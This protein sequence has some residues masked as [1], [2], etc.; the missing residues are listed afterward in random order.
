MSMCKYF[1]Y[2][3]ENVDRL[4]IRHYQT[5]CHAKHTLNYALIS[6]YMKPKV[7]RLSVYHKRYS[8]WLILL[9]HL[10]FWNFII[11][12]GER[13]WW[14]MQKFCT[15]ISFQVYGKQMSSI[16]LKTRKASSTALDRGQTM[17]DMTFDSSFKF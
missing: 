5:H 13:N 7:R 11:K 14:V 9:S 15:L 12:I 8:K 3:T 16:C 17:T 1:Y 6:K 2:S 10:I 4:G